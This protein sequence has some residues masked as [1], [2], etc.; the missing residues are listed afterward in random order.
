MRVSPARHG[1]AASDG[2]TGLRCTVVRSSP[3]HHRRFAKDEPR[4]ARQHLVQN[5]GQRSGRA[6]PQCSNPAVMR[7]RR[8]SSLHSRTGPSAGCR[9]FSR[10]VRG[11][12]RSL[13]NRVR[14]R[15]AAAP[16]RH[17]TSTQFNPGG[18]TLRGP[19]LAQAGCVAGDRCLPAFPGRQTAF[20]IRARTLQGEKGAGIRQNTSSPEL[21]A[22]ACATRPL[23]PR[24][25]QDLRPAHGAV[26]V[27][28]GGRTEFKGRAWTTSHDPIT[29]LSKLRPDLCT[30]E[31]GRVT[32]ES[33]GLTVFHADLS[34]PV[35]SV[36]SPTPT[37]RP[38]PRRSSPASSAPEAKP[39]ARTG[40]QATPHGPLL[41][42]PGTTASRSGC[43][44]RAVSAISTS[45]KGLIWPRIGRTPRP[46]SGLLR[47]SGWR[48]AQED[49]RG[50]H[51]RRCCRLYPGVIRP[52]Y[53][54]WAASGVL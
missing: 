27:S 47:R 46:V 1:T 37:C 3:L 45:T 40:L 15:S 8:N 52:S 53:A 5:V 28:R 36:S 41:P 24:V 38:R 10:R 6:R 54:P 21:D 19:Q 22:G 18:F 50:G 30:F 16:G 39:E 33:D 2:G 32:V 49:A 51:R 12:V 35:R 29:A 31:R 26:I 25:P 43:A 13:A 11:S 14:V 23:W 42:E 4:A 20:P 17:S 48:A 34:R 9:V 44:C 7:R